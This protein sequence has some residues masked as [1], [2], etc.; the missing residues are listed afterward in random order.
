M[1]STVR[2]ARF[3]IAAALAAASLAALS[4]CARHPSR[5]TDRMTVE[6]RYLGSGG[7]RS[8]RIRYI[9]KVSEVPAGAKQLRLWWPVPRSDNLQTISDLKF[10]GPVQPRL[11]HEPKYGNQIAYVE[12]SN[13]A[14][15][16]EFEMTFHC[17]RREAKVS[18]ASLNQEGSDPPGAYRVFREPDRLVVVDDEVRQLA[19]KA[20]Q[21]KEGTVQKARAIFDEVMSRMTY[22]K[23]GTGWGRGDTRFACEVG[24]GNCTDFHA[25]FNSLCR[26][27]GIPSGFE[28]GLYL[29][30]DAKKT[31]GWQAAPGGYHC[32]AA[33][34]VPGK[35]WVPVDIS[36]ADRFPERTE[37]FF[38]GHTSNRVTLSAG[39]DITLE[40]AQAAPPLNYL[41]D[42][43]A[44]V[45][46]KPHAASK[47][48]FFQDL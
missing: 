15:G 29:P 40:P 14:S 6:D 36:E 20:T 39:R 34:R 43:Y 18:L 1:P 44:E 9:A 16:A 26:A 5:S 22:D 11:G 33:F 46:G 47:T 28:I 7:G 3:P 42:P 13:P 48:W 38:G 24:K 45:D 41:L 27:E 32:W 19:R 12:L 31:E 10:S 21:G 23:S 25:L 30:Y 37:F 17:E 35:T 2:L 8:F 4:S